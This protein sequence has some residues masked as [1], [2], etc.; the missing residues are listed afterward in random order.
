MSYYEGK[1]KVVGTN[2]MCW[3]VSPV[4]LETLACSTYDPYAWIHKEGIETI[5]VEEWYKRRDNADK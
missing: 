5:S 1:I 4:T 3:P 2:M